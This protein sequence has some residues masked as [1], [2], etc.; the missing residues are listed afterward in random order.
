MGDFVCGY[1]V[2]EGFG[3]LNQH[4]R[5]ESNAEVG[6]LRPARCESAQIGMDR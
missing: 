1:L 4:Y 2:Q 6:P 5:I 3:L